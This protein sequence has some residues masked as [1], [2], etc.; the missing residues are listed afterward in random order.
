MRDD[1]GTAEMFGGFWIFIRKFLMPFF[2]IWVFFILYAANVHIVISAVIA[3]FSVSIV[4]IY[5]K[6]KIKQAN[7][8]AN[9]SQ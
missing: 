1:D 3:G 9:E 8:K 5:E 6:L 7:E 4:A 2:P